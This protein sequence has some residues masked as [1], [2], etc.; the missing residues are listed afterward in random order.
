MH[1]LE[2]RVEKRTF[3]GIS[4]PFEWAPDSNPALLT[5]IT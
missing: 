4:N 2:D 5:S 3:S 1:I